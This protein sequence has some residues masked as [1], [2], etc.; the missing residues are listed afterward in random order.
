MEVLRELVDSRY[1]VYDVLPTFWNYS[2]QEIIHG[3]ST[4][5]QTHSLY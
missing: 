3:R 2:E 5:L 4:L 1:T